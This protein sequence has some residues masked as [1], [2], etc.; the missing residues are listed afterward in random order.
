MSTFNMPACTVHIYIRRK[1]TTMNNLERGIP[2]SMCYIRKSYLHS[3]IQ[4]IYTIQNHH[5]IL[6]SSSHNHQQKNTLSLT[7]APRH[8]YIYV[9]L[10]NNTST[11]VCIDNNTTKNDNTEEKQTILGY[12]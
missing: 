1:S 4:H 5:R 8:L 11:R 10:K 2:A 6:P 12:N 9:K 3:T 7:A